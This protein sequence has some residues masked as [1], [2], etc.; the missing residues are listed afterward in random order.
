MFLKLIL[1]HG[2]FHSLTLEMVENCQNITQGEAD[3]IFIQL[4]CSIMSFLLQIYGDIRELCSQNCC[5]CFK[6]LRAV[7]T[8]RM[9]INLLYHFSRWEKAIFDWQN[10]V[11]SNEEY[12]SF[13]RSEMNINIFLFAITAL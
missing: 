11:L 1:Q 4:E 3:L 8:T 10:P 7:S 13:Y 6:Q 2:T 12:P 5:F 9:F